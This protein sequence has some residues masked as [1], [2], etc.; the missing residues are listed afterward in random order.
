VDDVFDTVIEQI[1]GDLL[2]K[3][4]L[5]QAFHEVLEHRSE[6]EATSG[7]PVGRVDAAQDYVRHKLAA[8]RDEKVVVDDGVGSD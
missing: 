3:T 8:R 6:M 1:P 5:A 4:Q 7:H 2:R